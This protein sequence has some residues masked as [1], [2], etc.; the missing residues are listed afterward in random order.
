MS[1]S[2]IGTSPSAPVTGNLRTVSTLSVIVPAYREQDPLGRC[3]AAL[4]P[5]ARDFEAEVLVVDGGSPDGTLDV[6]RS[7]AGVSVR[8]APLGRGSQMNA[9]ARA[10]TGSLLCFLP[11]DTLLPPGALACLARIARSGA[12]RSGGFRMRFD[13][14]RRLLRWVARLHNLRARITG[15][16]YG[17]QVPFVDRALFLDLGGYREDTDMEDIEFGLRLR[18][19][20]RPSLLDLTVTTSSRRFDRAGDL[21]ATASAAWLLAYWVCLRKAPRSKTFFDPVR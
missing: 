14:D 4:M 7:H 5:Q 19:H 10:A 9:G 15:V 2:P 21:R 3:L 12:P 6:A 8:S 13:A 1:R 17:D 16:V 11:A 20:A 18:R